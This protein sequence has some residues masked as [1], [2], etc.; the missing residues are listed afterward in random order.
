MNKFIV[1]AA[2]TITPVL[3]AGGHGGGHATELIAPFVNVL[4]LASFLIWKL[5]TPMSNYFK[6]KSADVSEVME[7]ASVKAREAEMMLQMQKTKL[8]KLD[9]EVSQIGSETKK[10]I[11]EFEKEY[12]K[13][14]EDRIQKLKADASQKIDSEKKEMMEKVSARVLDEVIARAKAGVKGNEALSKNITEN[15]IQG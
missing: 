7:R 4:I 1:L 13:N 9:E 14:I 6:Q 3:A 5:K 15:L 2:F 12:E 8:D 11:S 10:L